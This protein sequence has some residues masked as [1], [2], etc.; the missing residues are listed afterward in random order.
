[1]IRFLLFIL[2][3]AVSP[4]SANEYRLTSV[5]YKTD[6]TLGTFTHEGQTYGLIT[7]VFYTVVVS[8]G[9]STTQ[10]KHSGEITFQAPKSMVPNVNALRGFIIA[11]VNSS[12]AKQ[13]MKARLAADIARDQ[14]KAQREAVFSDYIYNPTASTDTFIVEGSA[15]NLD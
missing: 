4:I 5:F 11:D 2:F 13:R 1:M 10:V 8:T 6:K 12:G 9:N 15:L 14:E 7:G 3:F